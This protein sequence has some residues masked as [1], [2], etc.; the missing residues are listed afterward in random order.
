MANFKLFA[1]ILSEGESAGFAAA[2]SKQARDWYRTKASETTRVDQRSLLSDKDRFETQPKIGHMYLF[3]YDPKTKSDLPYYD[4]LPI[5]FPFKF[6]GSSMYGI[7]MHYLP[8]VYRA[9]LMDALYN[10]ASDTKY[11]ANT[12][13]RISYDILNKA[14]RFRFFKPCVKQYLNS[15]IRSRLVKIQATEWDMALFLPLERFQ[16]ASKQR[17]Y[18]DSIKQVQG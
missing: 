2:K 15:H 17:V 14:A 11:D 6:V 13:L 8:P 12:K 7:N 1:D 9:K 10:I 3:S 5:I 16:K 4:R 18:R